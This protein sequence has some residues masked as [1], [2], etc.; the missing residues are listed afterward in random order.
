MFNKNKFKLLIAGCCLSS[1]FVFAEE[2][3]RSDIYIEEV[4]YKGSG[5]VEGTA[6]WLLSS[7]AKTLAMLFNEYST[8]LR[9][10]RSKKGKLE[11]T[12]ECEMK[13]KISTPPNWSFSVFSTQ[14]RGYAFLDDGVE[15]HG[16]AKLKFE[17]IKHGEKRV[18]NVKFTGPYDDDFLLASP[19]FLDDLI[20]TN[21]G[22]AR[23][24][25]TLSLKSKIKL[26]GRELSEGYMQID[27]IDSNISQEYG[28]VWRKCGGSSSGHNRY[29]ATCQVDLTKTKPGSGS[30]KKGKG[31]GK[32]KKPKKPKKHQKVISAWGSTSSAAIE[33]AKRKLPRSC[34]AVGFASQKGKSGCQS[35]CSVKFIK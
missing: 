22:K 23:N 19:T 7:D 15:G 18:G 33:A 4:S 13:L 25:S 16:E 27:S 24:T 2:P 29:L 9:D 30:H 14:F 1:S 11:S 3:D 8:D 10:G 12:S 35:S 26:S 17:K 31:A 28:L 5:C 20:W 34:Q 6:E 32:E 21:C